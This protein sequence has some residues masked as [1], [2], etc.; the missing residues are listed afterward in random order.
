MVSFAA[1]HDV[2]DLS[3]AG[4]PGLLKL[5]RHSDRVELEGQGA[6]LTALGHRLTVRG[7]GGVELHVRSA[8]LEDAYMRL[9]G[10]HDGQ[11]ATP[12]FGRAGEV[13]R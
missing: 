13:V 12:V 6:L 11:M 8:G 10:Q 5:T 4:L 7:L 3:L 1:D 9:L 2:D